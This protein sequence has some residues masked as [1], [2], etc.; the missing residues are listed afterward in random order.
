[1]TVE[2]LFGIL[3]R[4][5]ASVSQW[6]SG[7][8]LSAASNDLGERLTWQERRLEDEESN[9]EQRPAE[10]AFGVAFRSHGDHGM[11]RFFRGLLN[12]VIKEWLLVASAV[13]LV[14]TSLY[15]HRLPV[16]DRGDL[17]ILYILF[18]FLVIIKGLERNRFFALASA[19]IEDGGRLPL[20]LVAVTAIL[21]MFVTNDV[22]LLIIV[23]LTLNLRVARKDILVILEVL[24]ANAGSALTPFGNPQN[25]FIY[26]FYRLRPVEFVAAIA[27]FTLFF[28]I[29]LLGIAAFMQTEATEGAGQRAETCRGTWVYLAFLALF[30]LAIL[31]IVPLYTGLFC[32]GYILLF[33]RA[34]LRV[35][36]ILLATFFCFFGFTDNLVHLLAMPFRGPQGVFVF[37]ALI[38]QL[39]SNVPS[40]LLVSDFTT[41][42]KALL[43]GVSVGGFGN[44][45]GSL[46][47][48]IAYRFYLAENGGS[49]SFLIKFHL[50]GYLFFCLGLA[51]YFLEGHSPPL[52]G[53]F[54]PWL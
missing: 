25:L 49:N 44:L 8:H 11:K 35:D 6:K 32:L 50:M 52:P 26:W 34:C 15:L 10:E 43:W 13:A 21:S 48:L 40:A 7:E 16:Y 3:L 39:I 45:I 17:E 53:P 5:A 41:H 29:V 36:Y 9:T 27:P 33:D 47:S 28:M 51:L 19:R 30:I 38:S 46:A 24:A 23:P 20:K 2:I 54:L 14:S 12:Q 18:T 22:A 1:M 42:W 4:R 31:K 37:T